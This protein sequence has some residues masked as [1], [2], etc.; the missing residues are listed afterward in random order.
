[1]SNESYSTCTNCTLPQFRLKI[2]APLQAECTNG[3]TALTE[4]KHN[5]VQEGVQ[6]RKSSKCISLAARRHFYTLYIHIY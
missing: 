4:K 3:S 1:M 2:I 6:L 5:N